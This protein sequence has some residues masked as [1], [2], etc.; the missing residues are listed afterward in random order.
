MSAIL[1][2]VPGFA[3][4]SSPDNGNEEP[5]RFSLPIRTGCSCLFPGGS[6]SIHTDEV[7]HEDFD[8]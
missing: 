2:T 6:T 1:R 8:S 3:F 5:E 4:L 7:R